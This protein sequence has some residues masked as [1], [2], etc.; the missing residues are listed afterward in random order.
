MVSAP[1]HDREMFASETIIRRQPVLKQKPFVRPAPE[2]S[3]T[4]AIARANRDALRPD[5]FRRSSSAGRVKGGLPGPE[6][7]AAGLPASMARTN[8]LTRP[9]TA[10]SAIMHR[11]GAASSSLISRVVLARPCW[12]GFALLAGIIGPFP[13]LWSAWRGRADEIAT[14]GRSIRHLRPMKAPPPFPRASHTGSRLRPMQVFPH[15]RAR[16]AGTRRNGGHVLAQCGPQPQNFPDPPHLRPRSRH[17][18]P[19]EKRR[20][21][22]RLLRCQQRPRTPRRGG[23]IIGLRWRFRSA[24]SAWRRSKVSA[25]CLDDRAGGE[26][27]LNST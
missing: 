16:H 6:P 21:Y 26:P 15:R 3:R 22:L 13:E 25:H 2:A 17:H 14:A 7:R 20:R 24:R 12:G 4:R 9:S 8:P 10:I 19:H 11:S 23:E 1:W 5:E 18:R 27:G